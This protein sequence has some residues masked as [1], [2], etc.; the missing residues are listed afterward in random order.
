MEISAAD[1]HSI[2]RILRVNPAREIK[3]GLNEE[4]LSVRVMDADRKRR[5]RPGDVKE[6]EYGK[7]LIVEIVAKTEA[8]LKVRNRSG[9][10]GEIERLVLPD[11]RGSE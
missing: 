2:L 4:K 8:T 3:R 7:P 10:N 1:K 5:K 9:G 6:E 11:V